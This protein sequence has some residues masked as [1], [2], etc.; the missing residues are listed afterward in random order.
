MGAKGRLQAIAVTNRSLKKEK[1]G[2]SDEGLLGSLNSYVT[3]RGGRSREVTIWEALIMR[4]VKTDL[5]SYKNMRADP[6]MTQ[7][8]QGIAMASING[9]FRDKLIL[10]AANYNSR[11]NHF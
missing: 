8:S 2:V 4:N 6:R 10:N 9:I 5:F 11:P 1:L 7:Q 3:K